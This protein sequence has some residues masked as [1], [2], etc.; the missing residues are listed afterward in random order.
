LTPFGYL[1]KRLK[2]EMGQYNV[3]EKRYICTGY[4]NNGYLVGA[5][6]ALDFFN[7]L[8]NS[9][10]TIDGMSRVTPIHLFDNYKLCSVTLDKSC[11]DI[12]NIIEE[13]KKVLIGDVIG[14]INGYFE[15]TDTIPIT[16]RPIEE[17]VYKKYSN[18]EEFSRNS[19]KCV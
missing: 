14:I 7:G 11:C 1:E 9:L 13:L 19:Y 3:K 10:Y 5:S 18:Y 12:K 8:I 2:R 17:S 16:V 4:I 6:D 15:S